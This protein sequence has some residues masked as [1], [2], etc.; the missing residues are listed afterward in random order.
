[1]L[2]ILMPRRWTATTGRRPGRFGLLEFFGLW[3]WC[4]ETGFSFA[5]VTQ[6]ACQGRGRKNGSDSIGE[7]DRPVMPG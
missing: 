2:L 6:F 7:Y 3:T 4:V 1:M 5:H